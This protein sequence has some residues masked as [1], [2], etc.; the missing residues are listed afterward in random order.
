MRLIVSPLL[1]ATMWTV[2]PVA[3]TQAQPPIAAPARSVA[4]S[5]TLDRATASKILTGMGYQSVVIGA[6]VQGVGGGTF[7]VVT[8]TP[9]AGAQ[10]TPAAGTFNGDNVSMVFAVGIRNGEV[11][12]IK[13][14]FFYDLEV[15]WFFV[16]FRQDKQ[17]LGMWTVSGYKELRPGGASK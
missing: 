7:D 4:I 8:V 3:A 15:G 6:V 12:T 10:L 5:R 1:L 16:E 9:G 17:S 2:V 14:T 11:T 13:E